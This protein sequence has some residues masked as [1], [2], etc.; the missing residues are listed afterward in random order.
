[1]G[2]QDTVLAQYDAVLAE[3]EPSGFFTFFF[4]REFHD[5]PHAGTRSPWY[6]GHV[7]GPFDTIAHVLRDVQDEDASWFT[8]DFLVVHADL[9][10]ELGARLDAEL[11]A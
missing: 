8:T 9:A 2:F 10:A 11:P 5:G 1:M 6:Y 3:N 4:R 7:D